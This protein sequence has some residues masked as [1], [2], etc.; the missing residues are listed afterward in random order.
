MLKCNMIA[1][2][3]LYFSPDDMYIEL[4]SLVRAE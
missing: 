4:D 2:I 1:S 3:A